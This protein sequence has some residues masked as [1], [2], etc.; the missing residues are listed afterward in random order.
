MIIHMC[1]R[2]MQDMFQRT[3]HKILHYLTLTS[4]MIS[5]QQNATIPKCVEG[6]NL[7]IPLTGEVEPEDLAVTGKSTCLNATERTHL[8]LLYDF[9]EVEGQ[10]SFMSRIVA[11]TFYPSDSGLPITL[12]EVGFLFIFRILHMIHKV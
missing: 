10:L 5:L 7:L 4:V 12:G 3:I 2:G 9:E 8:P 1:L 6:T 11:L